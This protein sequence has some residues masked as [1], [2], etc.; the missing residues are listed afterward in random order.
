MTLFEARDIRLYYETSRGVIHA[1]D[2]ISFDIESGQA[3]GIVGE[4][5]CGKT[6]LALSLLRLLP[7]NVHT[8]RGS[9]RLDGQEILDIPEKEFRKNIRWNKISMVFQGAMNSLNPVM[10][11][12]DQIIEPLRLNNME[13]S[14]T[15]EKADKMLELVGLSTDVFRRYPHELSGGMKQRVVIAMALIQK[16]QVVILDEPT[17]ALD[18]SIQAQIMN[19]LKRL[20]Q[21]ENISMIFITHDIA[22]ASD[23]CDTLGVMYAGELIEFGNLEDIINDAK[24]PYTQS[25]MA[26]TPSL[27]GQELPSFIPGVPPDLLMPSES[28][29]FKDRCKY[30]FESCI[31][32]VPVYSV[33]EKHTAKCWLYGDKHE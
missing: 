27:Y 11:V 18:V 29:R 13:K 3:F 19:L 25:L 2:G 1:V 23:L 24:H 8:Y 6:S 9:L 4:S 20:K 22:L 21:R 33:G 10:R 28:C 26:S 16:P 7:K 31:N 17:S 30:A 14:T 32:K 15:R 12:G 5:G